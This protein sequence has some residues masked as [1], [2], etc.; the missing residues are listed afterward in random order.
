MDCTRN[1]TTDLVWVGGDDR[2][3]AMFEGVF[4]MRRRYCL[5]R[6]MRQ[7]RRCFLKM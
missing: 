4:W 6:W 1:V 3:L 5:I 2:R 7:S